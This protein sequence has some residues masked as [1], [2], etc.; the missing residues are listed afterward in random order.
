MMQTKTE[1]I[2]ERTLD[3]GTGFIISL[4]LYKYVILELEWL[5]TNAFLVTLLFTVV[6]FVR[7]YLWRRYFNLRT[8]R[9]YNESN[10]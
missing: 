5:W 10:R 9:K 8:I 4:L 7:G 2:I 6:S 1:S 3:I